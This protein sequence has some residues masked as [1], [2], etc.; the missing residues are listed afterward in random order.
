[1]GRKKR[2]LKEKKGKRKTQKPLFTYFI[3]LI[4]FL[5]CHNLFSLKEKLN[6]KNKIKFK[7]L[8][9]DRHRRSFLNFE[10]KNIFGFY[11]THFL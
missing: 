8:R 6:I 3:I 11:Q 2:G 10:K 9:C 4:I 7:A 5:S 1:M